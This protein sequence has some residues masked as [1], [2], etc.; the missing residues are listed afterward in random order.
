MQRVTRQH[1]ARLGRLLQRRRAF[2]PSSSSLWPKPANLTLLHR[3]LHS[4]QREFGVTSP[5][6][7]RPLNR[8]RP[9]L[10]ASRCLTPRPDRRRAGATPVLDS[11]TQVKGFSSGKSG[12]EKGGGKADGKA[13]EDG[14]GHT[15]MGLFDTIKKS[16]N[17]EVAKV[18]LSSTT[19]IT[20]QQ[21][22]QDS[23]AFQS[24]NT[25][26]GVVDTTGGSRW[27]CQR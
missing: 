6:P 14:A 5:H 17:D 21:T 27:R 23:W 19:V 1:G 9:L 12:G 22:A 7:G 15:T 18:R 2:E 11:M 20:G 10:A 26:D 13:K 3:P 25:N 4:R 8:S 24:V 16:F